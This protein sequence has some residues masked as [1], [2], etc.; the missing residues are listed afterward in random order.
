MSEL[1]GISDVE[2]RARAI[3]EDHRSYRSPFDRQRLHCRSCEVVYPC[4]AAVMAAA[5][6]VL[7]DRVSHL[8]QRLGDDAR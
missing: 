1:H 3:L 7:F 2:A 6:V 4:E 5:V 8:T